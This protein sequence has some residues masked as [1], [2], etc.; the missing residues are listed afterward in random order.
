MISPGGTLPNRNS[1]SANFAGA[2]LENADFT[3]A[4]LRGAGGWTPTATT[5]V[6]NT[7]RPDGSI[8][9]LAL[10]PG[11]TLVVGNNPLAITTTTNATFDA[12][13]TLQFRLESNW[14]SPIGFG[15]GLIPVLGGTLDLEV[16]PGVDP[17][18]LAGQTIQLFQ[19]N[20]P[21]LAANRFATLKLPD[22]GLT[23]DTSQLYTNGTVKVGGVLGDY[24]HDSVVDAAD[25]ALWR[26]T[27]GSTTNLASDGNVN[28]IIDAG[29]FTAWKSHFGQKVITLPGDFNRN[30]VVD[31]ADYIVWRKTLGQSGTGLAADSNQNGT[32]DAGDLAIWRSNFRNHAGSGSSAQPIAAVP[33]LAT[34]QLLLAGIL[35]LCVG[36]FNRIT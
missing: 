20:S 17:A 30:G 29:D 31:A 2:T 35:T 10:L 22:G 21:L 7:I 24:N 18:S 4:D 32:V 9:G 8:Q 11:E 36:R 28:G 33:E 19:W 12:A 34:M 16:A 25:Y 5:I 1:P 13:A 3:G 6:H 23:W 14:T 15:A 26:K 27:L